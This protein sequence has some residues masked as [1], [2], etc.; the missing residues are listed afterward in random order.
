MIEKRFSSTSRAISD[1]DS[2]FPQAS[3]VSLA[4]RWKRHRPRL[5]QQVSSPEDIIFNVIR[6][7]TFWKILL[8][9]HFLMAVALLAAVTLQAVA[10]LMSARQVVGNFIDRF[11]PVPAASYA[12]VIVILY[13]GGKGPPMYWYGWIVL[14]AASALV[15]AWIATIFPV[16]GSA[17]R[18]FSSRTGAAASSGNGSSLMKSSPP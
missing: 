13:V 11:S 9:F 12:A 6:E 8:F 7:G 15:M 3:S 2:R 10:V 18:P 5:A 16:S 4:G 14:A 1:L 17:G